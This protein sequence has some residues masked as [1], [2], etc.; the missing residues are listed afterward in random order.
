MTR[1]QPST[2]SSIGEKTE[3]TL[4]LS[5]EGDTDKQERRVRYLARHGEETMWRI[6]EHRC[7]ADWRVVDVELIKEL[8]LSLPNSTPTSEQHTDLA[9]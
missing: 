3:T 9:V 2:L 4:V 5:F 1:T 6:E 8:Q 7:D